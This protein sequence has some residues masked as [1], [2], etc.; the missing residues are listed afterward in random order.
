MHSP[1]FLI[2]SDYYGH[3]EVEIFNKNRNLKDIAKRQKIERIAM[4]EMTSYL[5]RLY[6]MKKVFQIVDKFQKSEQ[7]QTGSLVQHQG[8]YFIALQAVSIR[9]PNTASAKNYWKKDDPRSLILVSKLIDMVLYHA[10]VSEAINLVP[11]LR[12]ERYDNAITW[13]KE[14]REGKIIL[15]LPIPTPESEH[16]E[17]FILGSNPT[18]TSHY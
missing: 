8:L 4:S 12:L 17:P 14:A 10:A 7:Y 6:D 3:I 2:P 5:D 11:E 1:S 9:E 16:T 18:Y 15:D 13:L